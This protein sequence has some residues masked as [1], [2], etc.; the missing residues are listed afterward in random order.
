MLMLERYSKVA[1]EI[2]ISLA[3]STGM[4]LKAGRVFRNFRW[5]EQG[6]SWTRVLRQP[7]N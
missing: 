4:K 6:K 1:R 3:L 2:E 7:L 5:H